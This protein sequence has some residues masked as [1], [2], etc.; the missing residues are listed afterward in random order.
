[1]WNDVIKFVGPNR[2]V[3]IAGVKL[4]GINA[5]SGKKL[6]FTLAFFVLLALLSIILRLIARLVLAGHKNE[7]VRF[8]TQQ[9][10]RLLTA[11]V[12]LIGVVSIWFDD[13][14]RLATAIGL[15]TAGLA[16]AL[17]KVVTAIAGYF[18]ILRGHTFNV[19]DRITMGGVRGDVIGLGF[20]Q[21]T[22]MEMG[23]PPAV[24]DADP[25]MW[26][27]SRQYTGRIV[28]VTNDKIFEEPVYNYTREFPYIWEEMQI[29]ISM[30]AD[31]DRGEQ[32]LLDAADHHALH[33]TQLGT[34]DI[35]ELKRRYWLRNDDVYPRVYFRLTSNWLELT[36]RFLVATHGIR[37]VKNN[38]TREI[39]A[40]LEQA[41]IGIAST[42]FDV[43]G[44]P[45]LRVRSFVQ[46]H[47]A[48]S[49]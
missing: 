35:E 34:N 8:W 43:V 12:F 17:Q 18:V 22:I 5:E 30:N 13:P 31:R 45:E 20:I 32:I 42:T 41:G 29:W 9:A 33:V 28:T 7:R 23:Q 4:V 24:Q 37:E 21:T 15:V 46:E 47:T 3:E 38:M 16:F 19:G 48:Q 25:A 39:I 6:L 27:R 2:A 1:M 44:L 14:T 26:V 49:N 40:A 11:L 36:L 10:I